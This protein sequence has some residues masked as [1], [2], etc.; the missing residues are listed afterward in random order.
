MFVFG[1][2]YGWN[3]DILDDKGRRLMR[4]LLVKLS[5]LIDA[6]SWDVVGGG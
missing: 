4:V 5:L 2:V 3:Q 1:M 6:R